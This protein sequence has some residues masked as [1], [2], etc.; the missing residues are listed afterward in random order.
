MCFTSDDET[1]SSHGASPDGLLRKYDSDYRNN[2]AKKQT[3]IS[4]LR[5]PSVSLPGKGL[6]E[7]TRFNRHHH[8]NNLGCVI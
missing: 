1:S 4:L 3:I 5:N 6:H 8:H 2:N 7:L